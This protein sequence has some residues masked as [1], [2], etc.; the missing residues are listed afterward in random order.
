M[1]YIITDVKVINIAKIGI[2]QNEPGKQSKKLFSHLNLCFKVHK[3]LANCSWKFLTANI[4]I[5]AIYQYLKFGGV[6]YGRPGI[7]FFQISLDNVLYKEIFTNRKTHS[8][9]EG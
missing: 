3:L 1:K 7:I 6:F 8:F 9:G 4:L 2:S 5:Y